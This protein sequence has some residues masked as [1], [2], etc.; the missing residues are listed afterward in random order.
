MYTARHVNH[1]IHLNN[2]RYYQSVHTV[3]AY[4]GKVIF[5]DTVLKEGKKKGK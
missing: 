2:S 4:S 5:K 1:F 3:I